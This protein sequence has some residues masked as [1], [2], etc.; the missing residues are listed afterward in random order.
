MPRR[1]GEL[2]SV[3]PRPAAAAIFASPLSST[4]TRAASGGRRGPARPFTRPTSSTTEG[5]SRAGPS[6]G[7]CSSGRAS[8]AATS[9]GASKG[10]A[11]PSTTATGGPGPSSSRRARQAIGAT[12]AE[13]RCASKAPGRD[14]CA[15]AAFM[16][17]PRPSSRVATSGFAAIVAAMPASEGFRSGSARVRGAG[18]A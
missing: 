17:G 4:A 5:P 15:R 13:A 1:G 7:R 12:G 10:L 8:A 9:R 18:G 14:R 3:R 2:R 16:R 6:A 11:R